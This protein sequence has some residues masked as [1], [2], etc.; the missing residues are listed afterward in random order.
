MK[1]KAHFDHGQDFDG[2]AIFRAGLETPLIERRFGFFIEAPAEGTHHGDVG[3]AA[4]FIH[5][6]AH[7]DRAL[8][9]FRFAC[10]G[11]FRFDLMQHAGRLDTIANTVD[12]VIGC[13]PGEESRDESEERASASRVH[14]AISIYCAWNCVFVNIFIA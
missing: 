4:F 13:L 14:G 7:G 12:V 6:D 5:H 11:V 10:R 1:P 2:I 3:G 9:P 8:N